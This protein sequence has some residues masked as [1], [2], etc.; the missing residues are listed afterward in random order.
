MPP[1]PNESNLLTVWQMRYLSST[2]AYEALARG[3][4]GGI[5]AGASTNRSEEEPEGDTRPAFAGT[6]L[7]IRQG[8]SAGV[9]EW[10]AAQELT[11]LE[12]TGTQMATKIMRQ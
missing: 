3:T 6:A 10:C 8:E 5:R 12:E 9:V 7:L 11:E 4:C 1:P 2:F